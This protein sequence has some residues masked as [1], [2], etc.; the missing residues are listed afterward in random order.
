MKL[1]RVTI[2]HTFFM[3]SEDDELNMLDAD[4]AAREAVKEDSDL[5]LIAETEVTNLDEVPEMYRDCCPYG[6]GGNERTVKEWLI[7]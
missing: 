2:E 5:D 4:Y 1:Y 6:E 7:G 3:V